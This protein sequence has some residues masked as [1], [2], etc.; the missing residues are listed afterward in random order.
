[1]HIDDE[2]RGHHHGIDGSLRR[3]AVTAAAVERNLEA[4]GIRRADADAIA[5]VAVGERPVVQGKAEIRLLESREQAVGQ[6][7]PGA[8]PD[9]FGGLGDEHQG[10]LPLVLEADQ[11]LRG[12]YP[13]RHV[14]VVAAAMRHKRLAALPGRLV[15]ACIGKAGFLF[16]RQRI[17]FGTHHDGGT[18]AILV[19]RDQAGLADLLGDLEADRAHFISEFGCGLHLL[20]GDLRMRMDILVKRIEFWVVGFDRFFNRGLEAD[21]VHLRVR[22]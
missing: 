15:V 13:A 16:H 5:D 2:A 11:C 7:G 21:D 8:P 1:M 12:P 4:V 6:H 18:V 14:D 9:F 20:E 17:E 3:R 10:A 22:G 19:D